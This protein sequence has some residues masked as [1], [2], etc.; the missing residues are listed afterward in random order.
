MLLRG[1]VENWIRSVWNYAFVALC[2]S[3]PSYAEWAS[4]YSWLQL[5]QEWEREGG[6]LLKGP[7]YLMLCPSLAIIQ[8]ELLLCW[9]FFVHIYQQQHFLGCHPTALYVLRTKAGRLLF[10]DRNFVLLAV[11]QNNGLLPS[12]LGSSQGLYNIV[13]AI[14]QDLTASIAY[15]TDL[16]IN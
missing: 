12:S 14:F 1:H 13:L 6:R 2:I 10:L 4:A 3:P 16:N 5:C 11:T 15:S 9:F 8:E 7:L